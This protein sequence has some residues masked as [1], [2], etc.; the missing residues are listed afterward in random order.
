VST[1]GIDQ[2]HAH[3]QLYGDDGHARR[4]GEWN[5]ALDA[6]CAAD[7]RADASENQNAAR[8][9]SAHADRVAAT[10]RAPIAIVLGGEGEC[11]A[12]GR[13]DEESAKCPAP[14]TPPLI[15]LQPRN[16]CRGHAHRAVRGGDDE[17]AGIA[18]VRLD[19]MSLHSPRESARRDHTHP[20]AG[21]DLV[22]LGRE[23]RR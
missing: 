4:A 13:A 7:Q 20:G 11:D 19:E 5:P 3:P 22:L 10:V 6:D 21:E 15:E 9:V 1:Y 23:D 16:R 8:G 17:R 14:S 12:E 2:P 18:G